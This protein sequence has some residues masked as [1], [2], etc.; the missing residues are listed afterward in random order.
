MRAQLS[1][2]QAQVAQ[3]IHAIVT[4]GNPRARMITAAMIDSL[5]PARALAF[6]Q[7]RFA[8]ASAFT[9]Y[10]VGAFDPDSMRPLV[11]RWLASLPATRAHETWRDTGVRPVAG[12]GNIDAPVRP[13]AKTTMQLAITGA[14]TYDAEQNLLLNAITEVAQ[15]RLLQRLRTEMHATY[16][17][18]AS[19]SAE[20]W[21]YPHYEIDVSFD[22]A[23]EQADSLARAAIAVLDTL[24][25]GGPTAAEAADVKALEE[26]RLQLGQR[27]N[28]YILSTLVTDGWNGWSYAT[29]L[30]DP[31]SLL[32]V[33]TPERLRDAAARYVDT[34]HVLRI[35][36]RPRKA[37]S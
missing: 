24:R 3:Q 32:G 21:P 29:G 30:A 18:Q 4:R 14:M 1:T 26:R 12:P 16:G 10:I 11:E 36:I 22:A 20:Q 19:A 2:A 9:F 37:T 8:D 35:A 15:R 33:L 31:A 5:D 28:G 23:P 25:A 7:A 13:D 27:D 6:H 17:V 34:A